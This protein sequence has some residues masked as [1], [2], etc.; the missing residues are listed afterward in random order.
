MFIDL[1][2]SGVIEGLFIATDAEIELL[3]G[4]TLSFGDSPLGNNSYIECVFERRLVRVVSTNQ[5]LIEL[6]N[7]TFGDTVSGYNP[8]E[9]VEPT[10]YEDEDLI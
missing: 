9:Q 3:A 8:F 6:L 10:D 7:Q 5:L 2:Q 1:G 4:T